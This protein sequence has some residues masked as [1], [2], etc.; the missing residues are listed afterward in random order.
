[1]VP[2]L[3]GPWADTLVEAARLQPGERVLDVACGTGIVARKAEPHVQPYG[4]VAGVD[5]NADMLAVARASAAQE[6]L[7]IEWHNGRAEKLPFADSSFDVV[8]CQFA[9][10]FFADHAAALAEMR[11]VLHRGGRVVLS[12]FQGIERHPFYGTLDQA[13]KRR[14]GMSTIEEIYALGNAEKL[15]SMLA[16]AGFQ[17]IEIEPLSKTARFP[18]PD[19]FLAGEIALDTAAIP[20]MQHLDAGGQGAVVAAISEEM[21]EPLRAVTEGDTVVLP[22]HVNLVRARA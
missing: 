19:G 10:M 8:L 11:R 12:V 18:N 6:G 20:S 2:V 3:F 17:G 22:F 9:L 4:T 13:I 7:A 21:A 15:R 14:L 16:D 1:M 5:F